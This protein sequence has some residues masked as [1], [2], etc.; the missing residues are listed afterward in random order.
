MINLMNQTKMR[1]KI[2]GV[3]LTL[4]MLL[5]LAP[6]LA[7]A[8]T[9]GDGTEFTLISDIPYDSHNLQKF[10]VYI[11][12]GTAP[13][14][15]WPLVVYV[16][17]GGFTGGDKAD[18]EG[19]L[20]PSMT[21]ARRFLDYG[22]AMVSVNYRLPNNG[23]SNVA[24]VY[25]FDE[26]RDVQAALRYIY[27]NADDYGFNNEKIALFGPSAGGGLIS[28]VGLA[29]NNS[30]GEAPIA[31]VLGYAAAVS[32]ASGLNIPYLQGFMD[33]EDP[34]FYLTTG[35]ADTT[36]RYN[37]VT[38]PFHNALLDAGVS[39]YF[40]EVP[41]AQ[42]TMATNNPH[43]Y[44]GLRRIDMYDDGFLWLAEVFAANDV[45]EVDVSASVKKLSG[46]SNELTLTVTEQLYSGKINE[47]T[48]TVTIANNA[49]GFYDVGGYNVYVDTKGNDQV[50][51]C[52]IA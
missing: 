40:L 34:P 3:L 5:T 26:I 12:A 24:S 21:Y 13:A 45:V 29:A 41:D 46:N 43:L 18:P 16:H 20:S 15:G 44:E 2:L 50:R 19:N 42:H 17:G 9:T 33:A 28:A 31:A 23:L 37:T 14:G 6:A 22:W 32:N 35:T 39:S 38:I 36:V 47:I 10:D 11:P 7:L 30:P 4:A 51:S 8:G 48:V 49:A 1:K 27:N 52:Y 25:V